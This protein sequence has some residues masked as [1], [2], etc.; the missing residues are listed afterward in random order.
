MC[1]IWFISTNVIT[2]L[3]GH[4]EVFSLFYESL[5][6]LMTQMHTQKYNNIK[7]DAY[8]QYLLDTHTHTLHPS[9]WWLMSVQ[10]QRQLLVVVTFA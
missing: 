10:T 9:I 6:A 8:I 4:I 2:E 3:G 5:I 7:R 1:S